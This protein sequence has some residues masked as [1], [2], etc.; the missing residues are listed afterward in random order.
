MTSIVDV[1]LGDVL[2][3]GF[4]DTTGQLRSL[5]RTLETHPAAVDRACWHW[6]P[7]HSQRPSVSPAGTSILL[8][9]A[10]ITLFDTGVDWLELTIDIGWVPELT[11]S[12]AVEVACWCPQDH[13]MHQVRN[14]SWPVANRHDLVEGFAAATA[15]L[16]GVL[17]SDPPG[18]RAWRRAAGLPDTLQGTS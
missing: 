4:G 10:A 3:A 17:D 2:P 8:F 7:E 18:P 15:M 16:A 9:D 12:A 11:V 1:P 6:Y 13:N 14:A 5:A